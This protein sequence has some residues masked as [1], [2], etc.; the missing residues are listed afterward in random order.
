MVVLSV[1]CMSFRRV[2]ARFTPI[3]QTIKCSVSQPNMDSIEGL[4]ILL[5][6]EVR[7]DNPNPYTLMVK[8]VEEGKI[9]MGTERAGVG[10]TRLPSGTLPAEGAGVFV[11]SA[12]I[13][14]SGQLL[15]Q[16]ITALVGDVPLYMDLNLAVDVDVNFLLG[17]FRQTLPFHKD[18]GMYLVGVPSLL[19]HSDAAKFG[20]MACVEQGQSINIPAAHSE[21]SD[22]LIPLTA[23]NMDKQRIDEAK[24][25][26]DTS[27][28]ASMAVSFTLCVLCLTAGLGRFVFLLC[29][30]PRCAAADSKEDSLPPRAV[31]I[32]RAEHQ[33]EV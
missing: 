32:G 1:V 33:E 12:D 22:G 24:K 3:Y 27:L 10:V 20:P 28:T 15:G 26:K 9:Y 6:V 14:L 2:P 7:C 8:S 13:D 16:L 17:S 5:T 25:L 18:C 31:K 11:T 21:S 29:R 4:R 23:P 30:A 19:A